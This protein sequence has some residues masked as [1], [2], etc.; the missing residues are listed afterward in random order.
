MQFFNRKILGEINEFTNTNAVKK[1][2]LIKLG[3][4]IAI[5]GDKIEPYTENILVLLYRN[6]FQYDEPEFIEIVIAYRRSNNLDE[7]DSL[8]S[9]VCCKILDPR[10]SS[11]RT[12]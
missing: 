6:L 9:W 12:Y 8:L 7:T 1:A 2:G 11:C 5:C 4:L 3:N 10:P